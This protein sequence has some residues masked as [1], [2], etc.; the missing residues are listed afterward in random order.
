MSWLYSELEPHQ[1]MV[2][3]RYYRPTEDLTNQQLREHRFAISLKEPS[4]PQRAGKAV[5]IM[6]DNFHAIMKLAAKEAEEAE[7][8]PQPPLEAKHKKCSGKR[9]I[10][11]TALVR[12]DPSL[13]MMARAVVELA[14]ER[15]RQQQK[16]QNDRESAEPS[17]QGVNRTSVSGQDLSS[18]ISR[19]ICH[20]KS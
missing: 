19:I 5:K 10:R 15:A 8:Q 18:C 6:W 1:Q 3:H 7:R 12:P 4:L 20:T 14:E 13:Q 16:E 2:I 11:I 17:L 9:P